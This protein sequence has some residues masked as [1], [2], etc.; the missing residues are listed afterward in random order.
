MFQCGLKESAEKEITLHDTS[1]AGFK[2]VLK[3]VY[4]GKLQ[5][6]DLTEDEL[7]ATVVLANQYQMPLLES[8]LVQHLA[9]D[10][11]SENVLP[12]FQVA[13]LLQAKKLKR[14]LLNYVRTFANELLRSEFFLHLNEVRVVM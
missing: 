11:T 13:C 12:R 7:L 3:Y 9:E 14:K 1:P 6:G 10:V 5:L 4:T 2:A 8:C